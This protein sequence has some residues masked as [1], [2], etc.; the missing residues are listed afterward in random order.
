MQLENKVTLPLKY[1]TVTYIV[2]MPT[3]ESIFIQKR[4]VIM[5]ILLIK[6]LAENYDISLKNHQQFSFRL[7]LNHLKFLNDLKNNVASKLYSNVK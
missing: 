4:L 2:S 3:I 7:Y 1:Y 6:C 5:N